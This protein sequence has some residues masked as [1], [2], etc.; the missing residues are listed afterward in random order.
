M[1][2]GRPSS[3]S[4]SAAV[5]VLTAVLG[6]SGCTNQ[7]GLLEQN[8]KSQGLRL[9]A[10]EESAAT[11][12]VKQAARIVPVAETRASEDI[13]PA[14]R[15]KSAWCDYLEADAAADATLLRSPTLGGSVDDESKGSVSLSLSFTGLRKAQLIEEGA[16]ARC[17]SHLAQS[18]LQKVV[19][20]APQTLSAAGYR[21]KAG[22][23]GAHAADLERLKAKIRTE[24]QAG[25]ITADKAASLTAIIEGLY[26]SAA[27]ARSEAERREGS[28]TALTGPAAE[29]SAEL[30]KAE[31]DLADISS[32]MRTADS[33]DV[34]VEAGYSD[35]D[36][37]NGLDYVEEGFTGKVKFSMKLGAFMPQ[38]YEHE[39]RAKNA[40]LA[41]IRDQEGGA[42]WQVKVLREAHM[43]AI[44]GLED[45]RMR[46]DRAISE[47]RR[48]LTLLGDAPEG[49]FAAAAIEARIR[50]I[51]LESDKAAVSGSLAEIRSK[52]EQLAPG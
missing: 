26:S 19:F 50:V 29:Y 12:D 4:R 8:A 49:E 39:Q 11:S 41:A 13:V 52:L 25:N 27:E 42:L 28:E 37:G 40:R 45:S 46:L 33:F 3:S 35:E 32:K 47:T 23:I 17:R 21:A 2:A 24:M 10:T 36:T 5:V 15:Q 31:S 6:V 1:P 22:A 44:S 43:K 20:L 34:S 7:S 38:R 9:T 48:F 16:E 18:G 14:L 51:Q 30:L